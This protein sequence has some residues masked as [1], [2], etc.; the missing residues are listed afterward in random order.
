MWDHKEYLIHHGVKGQKWGVR[1]YQNADG[2]LTEAGRKKY[3][4]ENGT[5]TKAGVKRI[6]KELKRSEKLKRRS[7]LKTQ[8]SD[9][10]KYGEKAKTAGKVALG[11]GALTVGTIESIKYGGPTVGKIIFGSTALRT[12]YATAGAA[13]YYKVRQKMAEKNIRDIKSGEASKRYQEHTQSM[14][15]AFGSKTI[16]SYRDS[17]KKEK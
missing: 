10:Q 2:T 11:A 17:I 16:N 12:V 8:E 15:N 6:N 14:I 1:R 7:N 9:V 4:T 13:G 3:Y 5:L